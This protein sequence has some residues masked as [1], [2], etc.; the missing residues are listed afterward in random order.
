MERETSSYRTLTLQTFHTN[1][2]T[3]AKISYLQA[4]KKFIMQEIYDG[5]YLIERECEN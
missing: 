3:D 5:L 1:P 4:F 2:A